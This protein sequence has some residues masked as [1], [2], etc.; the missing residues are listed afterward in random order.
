MPTAR[1][2]IFLVF[3]GHLH[4]QE[5]GMTH[6]RDGV[7]PLHHVPAMTPRASAGS[8]QLTAPQSLPQV[9][10]ERKGVWAAFQRRA[11]GELSKQAA[12]LPG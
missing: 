4:T 3:L 1:A 6:G 10:A 12:C 2:N 8:K 11:P 9:E 5:H 7:L